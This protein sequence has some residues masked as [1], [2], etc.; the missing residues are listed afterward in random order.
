M[1]KLLMLTAMTLVAT[2]WPALAEAADGHDRAFWRAVV[3]SGYQLPDGE[4]A[5]ELLEELSGMLGSPDP[6]LRDEF[7][8]GIT[9][10]W[11]Y[12]DKLYSPEELRG[13]LAEWQENLGAGL[14]EVGTQSVLLRSFSALNLSILAAHD[15]AEPFL[16]R[17]EVGSLVRAAVH[18]FRSERDLRGHDEELGWVHPLAHTA[19][20][21]KFLARSRHLDPSAQT[22]LLEAIAARVELPDATV[23]AWG[24]GERFARVVLSLIGRD[25]FDQTAFEE[26]LKTLAGK[27]EGLWEGPLD[28]A[29]YATVENAKQILR[30]LYALLSLQEEP[31]QAVEAAT[32]QTLETLVSM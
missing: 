12:R 20:L 15:N 10:R 6:E 11:V 2:A 28:H 9:A 27:A 18:Y 21:L 4:S 14:G 19:D 31:S 3:E 5:L 25:D 30:S 23:Y 8:Y 16:D 22:T 24:E 7:G 29:R 32:R 1:K 13:V 26:W 17:E